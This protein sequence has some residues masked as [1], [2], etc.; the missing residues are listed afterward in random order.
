MNNVHVPGP[1]SDSEI[2]LSQK[3]AKCTM[4]T[5][6]AQPARTGRAQAMLAW[7]CR[8]QPSIVSWLRLWPCRRRR[9]P[10]RGRRCRVAARLRASLRCAHPCLASTPCLASQPR[11]VAPG[12]AQ[13][14][15]P[16][17]N[18]IIALQYNSQHPFNL[19]SYNTI[20]HIAIQSQPP[21]CNT[22]PLLLQYNL[23]LPATLSRYTPFQTVC[24]LLQYTSTYFNTKPLKPATFQ[25]HQVM[26]QWLYCDPV[27]M[28]NGQ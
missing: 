1:I 10:Y 2:V 15:L 12:C 24:P 8:G 19:A 16:S 23:S 25:P 5:A 7:P 4:C 6:T 11:V 3:L 14:S 27:L 26:I 28:L 9:A 21:H 13:A 18:T 20:P 17:H 22:I